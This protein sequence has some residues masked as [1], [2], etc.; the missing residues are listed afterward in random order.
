MNFDLNIDNYTRRELIQMFDL[1]ENFDKTMVELNETKL[2]DGIIL[3]AIVFLIAWL[4]YL[5]R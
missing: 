5:M 2:K 3:W 4:L 1:P